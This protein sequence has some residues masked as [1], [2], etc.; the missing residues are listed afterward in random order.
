MPIYFDNN[1]TTHLHPQV[2][3]AMQPY[4]S[5]LHGNP[6]SLHRYGR[7]SRDA[8]EAARRDVASLVGADPSEVIWTSGGTESSNLAIKGTAGAAHK[9]TRLLYGA[10]E[11]AAVLEPVVA[12]RADGWTVEAIPVS[13]DGQ[14]DIEVLKR[15]VSHES[16]L[17]AA[18]MLANNETGVIQDIASCSTIIH[19]FGGLILV[20]AA[21]AAG[22]VPVDFAELKADLLVLSAHK[23]HGPLGAG[24][25][26]CRSGIELVP[27]HHGGGQEGG[28]RG[29]T[30]NV[31]AIVGFA[32]AA[33]LA[34]EKLHARVAVMSELRSRLEYGLHGL[35]GTHVF[36]ESSPRLPNTVL[37]SMPGY[38]GEGL[39]MALDRMGIA[40]SSGSACHS[41]KGEPSHVLRAMGVTREKAL[42][43]VRVSLSEENSAE[44]V[45]RFLATLSRL[46]AQLK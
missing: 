13:G 9:I 43:A 14:L 35:T 19:E 23:L 8:I 3:D 31:A 16:F 1:A 12:M 28:L 22:K 46:Q 20:D 30:E 21:Q 25:L 38:E 36:A 10:T 15:C 37:F 11:H 24:A 7:A 33:N 4:L 2:M 44:E 39:V 41:G 6:S 42:G 17:L 26:V 45:D 18:I 5:G 34:K 40:V 29:G 32:A 27:L